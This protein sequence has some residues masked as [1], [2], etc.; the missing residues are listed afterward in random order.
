MQAFLRPSPGADAP[1]S[2]AAGDEDQRLAGSGQYK[3]RSP[4]LIRSKLS[5]PRASG[6]IVARTSLLGRL[7][8]THD[9]AVVVVRAP[10]GYGKSSVLSQWHSALVS[11]GRHAGWCG[12]DVGD[13]D[14][15]AFFRSIVCALQQAGCSLGNGAL[16][17]H[18][19]ELAGAREAFVALLLNEV[20]AF[21]EPV[22]L[23]LD[24]FHHITRPDVLAAT[25][26]LILQAP[27]NFHLVLGSRTLPNIG[28]LELE[29]RERAAVFDIDELRF[30]QTEA[31]S[32]LQTR[33]AHQLGSVDFEALYQKTEG[34]PAGLQLAALSL[35]KG[36]SMSS[37]TQDRPSRDNE[38]DVYF[39]N[40]VLDRFAPDVRNFL[41]RTSILPRFDAGL[42]DAALERSDSHELLQRLDRDNVFL[43][44]LPG[45]GSWHR[46][47]PLFESFLRERFTKE[48]PTER[49]RIL[50]A[51]SLYSERI[52]E[53]VSAVHYAL[54]ANLQSRAASLVGT[55]ALGMI[56]TGEIRTCT[57]LIDQLP[58]SEIEARPILRIAQAWALVLG[59]KPDRVRRILTDLVRG[60]NLTEGHLEH[61]LILRG[62]CELY[63]GASTAC[64]STALEWAQTSARDDAFLTSVGCNLLTIARCGRGDF[65][66]AREA[67]VFPR[68][69]SDLERS[70]YGTCYA[71]CLV[72]F[73]YVRKGAMKAAEPIYRSEL[74]SANQRAG[75]RSAPACTT[76]SFYAEV[77]YETDQ[78]EALDDLL[79]D[80]LDVIDEVALPDVLFQTYR[81]HARSLVAKGETISAQLTLER[82]QLRAE[83]RSHHLVLASCL[84]ERIRLHQ[85]LDEDQTAEHLIRELTALITRTDVRRRTSA[86]GLDRLGS[87][88][89]LYSALHHRD[90][91]RSLGLSRMLAASAYGEHRML[92]GIRYELLCG[93]VLA[94]TGE[95]AQAMQILITNLRETE[96]I[97][98]VRV[99][100]DEW[101]ESRTLLSRSIL[102]SSPSCSE[103]HF[104]RVTQAFTSTLGSPRSMRRRDFSGSG[105]VEDLS[106]KERQVLKLL[107]QGLQNKQIAD[108][109]HLSLNTV[110]W[111][112]KNSY[113]KLD[114]SQR[115]KAVVKARALGLV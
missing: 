20:E 115:G 62:V 106:D 82:L 87:C 34:W 44:R 64:A 10:A 103:A 77:L 25:S 68:R 24:D 81:A 71:N 63:E 42:A 52:G 23:V 5:P 18:D 111:H 50:R 14:P 43:I 9:M 94:S 100:A 47:H 2:D 95:M 6:A 12:L 48:C 96:F 13:N 17:L 11:D 107:G 58:N 89:E 37:I 112:L 66:G 110:K 67:Q 108:R 38:F 15:S 109:L 85:Y 4:L 73:T 7:E 84:L 3:T 59:N 49:T 28:L 88:A 65:E 55:S 30:T 29:V 78:L 33:L 22:Y 72:A 97:G 53:M 21:D 79:A 56:H 27:S 57:S 90:W 114:V 113:A 1:R 60:G 8:V 51:A 102:L 32:F 31:R 35:N 99:F 101:P 19:T 91:K 80:R 93:R 45:E 105:L 104:D 16:T 70:M 61:V 83:D 39:A 98:A 76:A 86:D 92:D 36:I 40:A 41:V 74:Q 75:R 46:Y 26:C 54:A 69:W